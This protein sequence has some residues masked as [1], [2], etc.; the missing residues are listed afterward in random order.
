[1]NVKCRTKVL[2][3]PGG[4]LEPKVFHTVP[5]YTVENLVLIF[6]LISLQ[7]TK[8]FIKTS[9]EISYSDQI[10]TQGVLHSKEY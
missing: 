9:S 6:L 7:A 2:N 10:G 8:P 3:A 1:M 5:Q 4:S